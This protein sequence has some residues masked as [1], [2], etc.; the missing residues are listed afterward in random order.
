M[1]NAAHHRSRLIRIFCLLATLPVFTM[2]ASRASSQSSAEFPLQLDHV[3][4]WVTKGAPEAKALENAGLT[5]Q[6][7]TN[8][9]TG[10]GTAS[11]I[12]IFANLYLEVIW[13]EDAQAAEK[14]GARTGIDMAT[15]ADWQ[16]TGASPFGVGLHRLFGR[17][18]AIPFPVTHYWAEW[19][20]P[21]TIIEFAQTVTHRNE[22]MFFVV[23][24]YIST[25]S[26]AAE[27]ILKEGLKTSKHRLGVSRV[28]N[29]R[30]VLTGQ[31]L[32]PTSKLLAKSGIIEVERGKA[33][34]MELT[35]DDGEK[36]KSVDLRP[37][38]PIVLKY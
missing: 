26:P 4:I 2:N 37:Q 14:N 23:P 28:S 35:F 38:L 12:F 11:K 27:G 30:V 21:K 29:L 13:I 36:S 10:Q 5:I 33:P 16:R 31:K 25:G 22:P 7:R 9:H 18:T 19:M 32:T 34:L 17:E 20:Q 15:R 3:F 24:D 6:D 8:Q 1:L